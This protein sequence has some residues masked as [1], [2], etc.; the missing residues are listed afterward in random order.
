MLRQ[1]T[2]MRDKAEALRI[3]AARAAREHDATYEAIG[4]AA[5][6][7]KGAAHQMLTKG[8]VA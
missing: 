1:A 5:G 8:G 2:D 3:R 6:I 7:T 4:E